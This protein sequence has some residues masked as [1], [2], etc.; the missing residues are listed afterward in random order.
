MK[1][2]SAVHPAAYNAGSGAAPKRG[3]STSS[4][5]LNWRSPSASGADVSAQPSEPPRRLEQDQHELAAD[6]FESSPE[7]PAKRAKKTFAVK[8]LSDVGPSPQSS[9]SGHG[10]STLSIIQTA[11]EEPRLDPFADEGEEE[12]PPPNKTK[13]RERA[14]Q[15][16]LQEDRPNP[17]GDEPRTDR[18]RQPQQPPEV[19]PT[20][21][22]QGPRAVICPTPRDLKPLSQISTNIAAEPGEF[23][24]ECGLG[25]DGFAPRSWSSTVMAWKASALCHK[26]LYFEDVELERYG[27]TCSPLFQP[28]LS[29]AKFWLTV[30]ILPYKFGLEPPAECIY[31]LGYYRP[32]SCAPFIIPPV[33]ISVRGALLEAGA[34][35]AGVAIVP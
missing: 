35:V 27:Q 32:G 24:A 31:V 14:V 12:E 26:P 4:S 20:E 25:D 2:D 3:A 33:P 11:H 16:G 17:F 8:R 7:L 6:A 22:A 18:A 9:T 34:W 21:M 15:A 23:P 10:G 1:Q 28:A 29:A 30:P 5:R 13:E 19:P